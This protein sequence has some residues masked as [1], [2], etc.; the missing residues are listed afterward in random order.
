M[1]YQYYL[2]QY[3]ATRFDV[4]E[5]LAEVLADSNEVG[6][7]FKADILDYTA[8]E[9]ALEELEAQVMPGDSGAVKKTYP[10]YKKVLT[11]EEKRLPN[12]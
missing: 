6:S 5:F 11:I 10:G 12:K 4:I 7:G 2:G 9:Q 1:K 3:R 8:G